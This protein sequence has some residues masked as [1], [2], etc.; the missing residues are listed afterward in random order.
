MIIELGKYNKTVE[1]LIESRSAGLQG[2]V[3]NWDRGQ[4]V[5]VTRAAVHIGLEK[6]RMQIRDRV[7]TISPQVGMRAGMHMGTAEQSKKH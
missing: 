2:H 4:R 3:S 1:L 7:Q 5:S 6:M